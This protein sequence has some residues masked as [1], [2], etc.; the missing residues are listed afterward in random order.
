MG[1][2]RHLTLRASTIL[3]TYNNAQR[4]LGLRFTFSQ[5]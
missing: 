2:T 4:K 3:Y 5:S 1:F